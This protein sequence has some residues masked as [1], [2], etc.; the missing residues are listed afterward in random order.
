MMKRVGIDKNNFEKGESVHSNVLSVLQH[1]NE[2]QAYPGSG[3]IIG[4]SPAI[5]KIR[6]KICLISQKPQLPVLITGETG[7]GKELVANALHATSVRSNQPMI[8]FNC[9]AIPDTL[10]ES[11]LFGH[12][13]GAFTGATQDQMGLVE[14]ANG[15]TLLFDEIGEMH[16][17]LQP[18]LLRFLDTQRF[19]RVGE[20]EER[21]VDVWILAATNANLSELIDQKKFRKDLYYR[22]NVNHIAIPPLRERLH[23]VSILIDY[24]IGNDGMNLALSDGAFACFKKYDWPGNVRELKNVINKLHCLN[25]KQSILIHDLPSELQ[26]GF[27]KAFS[28]SNSIHTLA[29]MEKQYIQQVFNKNHRKI[30]LTARLLGITRNT[31]KRKMAVHGIGID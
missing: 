13:K 14:R 8:R 22:L 17:R 20:S 21:Q 24:F 2:L 4:K 27:Q 10:L 19:H 3:P 15:G 7:T 29:E 26:V 28:L 9:S 30:R 5:Q 23:D 6:Q 31:L 18:K 11:Q 12:V 25:D 16:P 1:E